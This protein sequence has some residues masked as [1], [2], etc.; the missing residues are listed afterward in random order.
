MIIVESE[1]TIIFVSCCSM[2]PKSAHCKRLKRPWCDIAITG[3]TVR[4]LHFPSKEYEVDGKLPSKM[5]Q[6]HFSCFLAAEMTKHKTDSCNIGLTCIYEQ[7]HTDIRTTI[8]KL[9]PVKEHR[10]Q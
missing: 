1:D 2:L 6:I 10:R 3:L 7:M 8:W 5:S 4:F 9:G